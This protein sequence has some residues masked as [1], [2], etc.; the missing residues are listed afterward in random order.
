MGKYLGDF[1]SGPSAVDFGENFQA[2]GGSHSHASR[3]A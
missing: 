1:S 3:D 2:D